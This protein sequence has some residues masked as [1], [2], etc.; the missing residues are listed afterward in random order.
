M[1]SSQYCRC[2]Q[3]VQAQTIALLHKELRPRD[4]SRR[5]SAWQLLSS[6]LL[7]TVSCLSLSAVAALRRL[8]PS[9]E[10][11]F[12]AF[13]ATLPGYD[14]LLRRLPRLLCASLPR[15]LRHRPQRATSLGRHRPQRRYPLAIDLHGVPYYKR[16]RIPPVPVRKGKRL[17][18]TVYSLQYATACLLRKG[19]YYTVAL[20]PYNPGESLATLVKRL[21]QQ[22]ASKGFSPRY[23]LMDRSFWSADV[24]RYLQRAR[25]PFMLPVQGR[26]KRPEAAGGPTGTQQ[27]LHGL[28][29]S[30]TYPYR[31]ANRRGQTAPVLIV[32]HRR[33]YGGR[34]DRHGRYT[35]AYALWRVPLSTVQWVRE[36]YRRRFRIESSYRLLEAA[37][38]RTNSRRVEVRLWYVVLALLLANA[39]L[40][41]RWQIARQHGAKRGSE[42]CWAIRLL[43]ALAQ[44]LWQQVG[45]PPA[46]EQQQQ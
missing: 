24:F 12:Q 45:P 3:Q 30:G 26:G 34:R 43:A 39:W 38:G 29:R 37:R 14:R 25:Y 13:Y 41:A 18:G 15:S 1:R 33:N 5:C 40:Q 23:V 32:V 9:R 17:P 27:F 8:S 42:P 46:Q 6:L 4:F 36:S 20:T 21:L 31:V 2:A 16:D 7:A 11:L 35:W 10:T 44:V 22:A 28:C 19:Q